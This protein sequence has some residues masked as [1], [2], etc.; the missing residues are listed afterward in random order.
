METNPTEPDL[1]EH[2]GTDA[3]KWA[4]EFCKRFRPHRPKTYAESVA[5]WFANA[6][7]AGRLA[8]AAPVKSKWTRTQP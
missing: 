3:E 2:M 1:L 4:E 6:I 7:E 8:G 5:G